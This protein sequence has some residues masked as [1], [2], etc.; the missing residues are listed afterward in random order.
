MRLQQ[1]V[2]LSTTCLDTCCIFLYISPAC[3]ANT[4][5]GGRRTFA[6]NSWTRSK[7]EVGH[8]PVG[9][10]RTQY[11]PICLPSIRAVCYQHHAGSWSAATAPCS[12]HR[13][14]RRFHTFS[15]AHLP[16]YVGTRYCMDGNTA[17]CS[18]PRPPRST[19]GQPSVPDRCGDPVVTLP[20]HAGAQHEGSG[21]HR[22]DVAVP[23]GAA[24]PGTGGHQ[25]TA[26]ICESLAQPHALHI[27][28]GLAF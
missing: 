5:P 16:I 1:E 14:Q 4:A 21:N 27:I 23:G 9:I 28:I 10:N 19:T 18:P 7:A 22:S 8:Y 24:R 25:E 20:L 17:W 2:A 6:V 12:S 13:A 15:K 11:M 3:T 26:A